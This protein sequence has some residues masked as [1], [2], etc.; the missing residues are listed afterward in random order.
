MPNPAKGMKPDRKLAGW[1]IEFEGRLSL[2]FKHA[3]GKREPSLDNFPGDKRIYS[4]KVRWRNDQTIWRSAGETKGT[5]SPQGKPAR[6]SAPAFTD[7][8]IEK[9]LAVRKTHYARMSP[10]VPNNEQDGVFSISGIA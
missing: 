7:I 6:K 1:K 9:P 4:A 5:V 2:G 8:E 10:P 3:P